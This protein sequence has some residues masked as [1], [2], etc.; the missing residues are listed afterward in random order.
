MADFPD[1]RVL[2]SG[3]TRGQATLDEIGTNF[4]TAIKVNTFFP[5]EDEQGTQSDHRTVVCRTRL[6][7]LHQF[8]KKTFTF[9]KYTAEEKFGKLLVEETWD[10]VR[11]AATSSVAA[12]EMDRILQKLYNK[13]FP[14]KTRT[15]KSTDA[16]WMTE[17]IRRR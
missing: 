16:P 6:P 4:N 13:A 8:T 9:R 3:P 10:S 1:I 14:L 15:I 5:L 12:V 7:R 2:G 11:A 17:K